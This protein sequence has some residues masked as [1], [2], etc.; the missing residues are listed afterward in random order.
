MQDI[1]LSISDYKFTEPQVKNVA[2]DELK[3]KDIGIRL[4]PSVILFKL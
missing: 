3:T 1:S 4:A 2:D